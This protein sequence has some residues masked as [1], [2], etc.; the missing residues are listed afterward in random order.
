MFDRSDNLDD[1]IEAI[2]PLDR[3]RMVAAVEDARRRAGARAEILLLSKKE[4]RL[5]W[6]EVERLGRLLF[7]IKFGRSAPNATAG[8]LSLY[9]ELV[10]ARQGVPPASGTKRRLGRSRMRA[11]VGPS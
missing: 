7:F 1:L 5:A 6:D 8:E 2:M 4:A 11:P 3:A 10:A 9:R